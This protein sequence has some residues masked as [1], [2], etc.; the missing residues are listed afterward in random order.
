MQ[1]KMVKSIREAD[2]SGMR[3]P[4]IAVYKNPE[5]FPGYYAARVYDVDKPTDTVMV[6][7]TLTEVEMDIRKNT[8]MTFAPRGKEDVASLVGVWW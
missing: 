5:D 7:K 3:M 2:L 6:K 4:V 1:N 8:T